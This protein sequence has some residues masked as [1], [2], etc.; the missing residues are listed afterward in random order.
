MGRRSP[1][2]GKK[3]DKNGKEKCSTQSAAC[4]TDWSELQSPEKTGGSSARPSAH[5]S[6]E[7]I[8]VEEVKKNSDNSDS[9]PIEINIKVTEK[10]IPF[11]KM[12]SF[13]KQQ[14]GLT[15]FT[16]IYIYILSRIVYLSIQFHQKNN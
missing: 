10:G 5:P 15:I 4:L 7:E 3:E 11:L 1:R 16:L 9:I 6:R 8:N 12:E 2:E 14:N 13:V